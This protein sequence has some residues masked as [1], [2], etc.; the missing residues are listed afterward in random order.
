MAIDNP[1]I[2][3]LATVAWTDLNGTGL[4]SSGTGATSVAYVESERADGLALA[5]ALRSAINAAV[6]EGQSRFPLWVP[7]STLT[8]LYTDANDAT[9]A[10]DLIERATG[11]RPDIAS[12]SPLSEWRRIAAGLDDYAALQASKLDPRTN[13]AGGI[14]NVNGHW[15]VNGQ[16]VSLLDVFMVV[17]INQVANFDDSLN[18]YIEELNANNRLVKAANEWLNTLR[19]KKPAST[20]AADNASLAPAFQTDFF[21]KWGFSPEATFYPNGNRVVSTSRAQGIWDSNIETTKS[22]IEQRDTENQTA[23]QKLEQMTNRRSEV[24]E[25]LT[26]FIKSQSQTGQSFS[27]NLG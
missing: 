26:S 15:Y 10:A 3:N 23:Q 14:Q 5:A 8:P 7:P 9:V 17:R 22:Y 21:T 16:Q 27:R 1:T 6:N 20:A 13:A 19:G 25:G 4:S 2:G 24:L 12:A 18:I 11:I